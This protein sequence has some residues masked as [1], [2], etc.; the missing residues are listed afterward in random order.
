MNTR[1]AADG[2]SGGPWYYGTTA[3]GIHHGDC[4]SYAG[5]PEND[6]FSHITYFDEALGPSV[7]LS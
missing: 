7:A 1:E 5:V 6:C 2:D 3:Y 4:Y